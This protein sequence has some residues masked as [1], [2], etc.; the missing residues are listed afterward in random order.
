MSQWGHGG[1]GGIITVNVRGESVGES[2][3][4]EAQ[5]VTVTWLPTRPHGWWRDFGQSPRLGDDGHKHTTASPGTA[6]PSGRDALRAPEMTPVS[7]MRS[8]NPT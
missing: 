2:N 1:G 5:A 8:Q 6:P 3:V 7:P 4:M